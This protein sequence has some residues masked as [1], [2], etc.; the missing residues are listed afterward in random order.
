MHIAVPS[1]VGFS[2]CVTAR[3]DT[4]P[5]TV[6]FAATHPLTHLS[7]EQAGGL[8]VAQ[9]ISELHLS[10]SVALVLCLR[11]RLP[12][13]PL[14]VEANMSRREK[15]ANEMLE[16]GQANKAKLGDDG[17]EED[18]VAKEPTLKEQVGAGGGCEAI[19]GAGKVVALSVG[20]VKKK[21]KTYKVNVARYD[22]RKYIS[23]TRWVDK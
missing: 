9:P 12:Q 14:V 18:S 21:K 2:A 16:N 1:A 15:L 23:S 4:E 22:L 5:D 6:F 20:G 3:S 7:T 8:F 19:E 10:S 17:K 11:P 13:T